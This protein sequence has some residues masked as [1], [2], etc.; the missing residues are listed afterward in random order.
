MEMGYCT[1]EDIARVMAEQAGCPT[2][3][4]SYT[5]DETAVGL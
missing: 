3:L 4:E 1:E 2:S 5:V